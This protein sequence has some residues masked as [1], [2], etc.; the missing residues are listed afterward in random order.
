MAPAIAYGNTVVIK[1]ADLIP[2]STWAIVDILHRAGLPHGVVNLVMGRGSVVGQTMLDSKDVNAISLIGSVGMGKRVAVASIEV[3]RKFQLEMGSKNPTVV[4]DDADLKVAV[5]TV[6]QSAFFSTGQ[7]CTASSRV[8]VTE[9]IHDAFVDALR[10]QRFRPS[11]AGGGKDNF[12]ED[13]AH[14]VFDEISSRSI[15]IGD[16][17]VRG[18]FGQL[19]RRRTFSDA[20]GNRVGVILGYAE[21][22]HR[23]ETGNSDVERAWTRCSQ[24]CQIAIIRR[25]NLH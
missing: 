22:L 14:A 5:E 18:D 24:N 2:G 7:R 8:I 4:L 11:V 15:H 25:F 10:D 19:M 6:A 3:S 20:T 21:T 1:L 13:Y 23:I 17:P 9:G 12:A 16:Q